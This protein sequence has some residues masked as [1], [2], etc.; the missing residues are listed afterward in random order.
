MHSWY[1]VG[2]SEEITHTYTNHIKFTLLYVNITV[3]LCGSK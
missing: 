1:V 3:L 2:T